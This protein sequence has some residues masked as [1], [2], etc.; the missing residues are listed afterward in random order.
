M[1][2][3]CSSCSGSSGLLVLLFLPFALWVIRKIKNKCPKKECPCDCHDEINNI[4]DCC[5]ERKDNMKTIMSENLG[6]VTIC[7][8]CE[9]TG[10]KTCDSCNTPEAC[11]D[12][13]ACYHNI[14]K[15]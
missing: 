5:G 8:D 4:C 1:I 9:Y 10:F 2:I 7:E 6:G 15:E 14:P 12:Y 13:G 3:A 11:V